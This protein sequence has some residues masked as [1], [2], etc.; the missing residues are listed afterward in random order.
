MGKR[1][2]P[3]K[4]KGIPLLASSKPIISAKEARK[5]LGKD[6]ERLSD[7]EVA[8]IIITLTA[9]A[10]AFLRRPRFANNKEEKQS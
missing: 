6:A 10:S 9:L 4:Q 5:L 8:D 1:G 2:K 3:T 7:D